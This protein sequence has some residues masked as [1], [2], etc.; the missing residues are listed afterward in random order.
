MVA[1]VLGVEWVA[2]DD[3]GRSDWRTR[4]LHT[5]QHLYAIRDAY[6][7][8][9]VGMR[10]MQ[11]GSRTIINKALEDTKKA[12]LITSF[13]NP[14][15]PLNWDNIR[16]LFSLHEDSPAEQQ[17]IAA[18]LVKERRERCLKVNSPEQRNPYDDKL[19][20]QYNAFFSSSKDAAAL[21]HIPIGLQQR[22]KT[23]RENTSPN[24]E[25]SLFAEED[26]VRNL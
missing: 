15:P 11:L 23:V 7:L 25:C 16:L 1:K 22:M 3:L 19:K 20:V 9:P 18:L 6:Y 10:L 24:L 8:R 2:E 21:A 17:N 12:C 13:W 26:L 5:R 14:L 4:P